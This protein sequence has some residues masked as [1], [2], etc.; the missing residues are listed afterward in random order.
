MAS[1]SEERRVEGWDKNMDVEENW[2]PR[3]MGT[4]AEGG[5]SWRMKRGPLSLP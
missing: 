4:K 2:G 1:G 3:K 5:G